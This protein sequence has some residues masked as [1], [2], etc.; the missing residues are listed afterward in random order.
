MGAGISAQ[1]PCVLQSNPQICVLT[2]ET[3]S[4]LIPNIYQNPP[5]PIFNRAVIYSPDCTAWGQTSVV[6]N[7][8]IMVY[9]WG[10][11]RKN[12]LMLGMERGVAGARF[13]TPNFSYGGRDYSYGVGGCSCEGGDPTK[14][15]G[16][17]WCTCLF[18]CDQFPLEKRNETEGMVIEVNM[19]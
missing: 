14:Q 17:N 16:T 11:S 3:N 5:I 18:Q 1:P 7:D 4:G 15:G 10:L 8:P 2:W 9:A 13:N 19:S 12:P 6:S